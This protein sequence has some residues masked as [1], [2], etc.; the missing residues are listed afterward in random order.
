[1]RIEPNVS[2]IYE[3]KF[4]Q[5]F[6]NDVNGWAFS[7]NE[8]KDNFGKLLTLDIDFGSFCNL[9]CPHCFR[10][11]NNVDF[12]KN[13]I[14]DYDNIVN[15]V[16]EGKKLGLK[17]VKFL[18][19]G[20]P[21]QEK[22]FLEFL[23][24]LKKLDIIPLIFTKGH[25]IGDDNEVKKWYSQYGIS[26]GEELVEELKKV[27][28]SILLGFNSFD[29][30]IQDKMIGNIK[31]YTLKR[32]RALEL[33]AKAGF[34][35]HNPTKLCLAANPITNDNYEEIFEIYKWGRIRNMYVIVCPTMISGRCAKEF[36][37]HKITPSPEELIELYVKIYKFNLEKGIITM[38]QL[39]DEGIAPYAGGHP[40]NQVA[41]GMYVTLT[42][43]VLRC[44]GDD[45]TL[46][47][48]IWSESLRD[49]WFKSENYER[50]GTFNCVCPPKFGKSIPCDLFTKVMTRLKK[51]ND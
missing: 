27:N 30:E 49:I 20:E 31:G 18:G 29:T 24:E 15:I 38:K 39:E 4:P 16:K 19:A 42:G 25:V 9:N 8:M 43:K 45:R 28:A 32:N 35:K 36:E 2:T 1:M 10:K 34:N 14:I 5:N 33:L 13:K 21:F 50:A 37:W 51:D 48:D 41:C 6:V 40:C 12:G 3:N 44:P 26:T 17:S 22:R 46:L 23:R 47:G 11:N 7:Q